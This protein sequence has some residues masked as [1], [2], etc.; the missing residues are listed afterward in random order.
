MGAGLG[1]L[2]YAVVGLATVA[3]V[4][5]QVTPCHYEGNVQY[6]LHCY[7]CLELCYL[8]RCLFTDPSA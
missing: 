6:V 8:A 3:S 1:C 2:L 4:L 5:A 7:F